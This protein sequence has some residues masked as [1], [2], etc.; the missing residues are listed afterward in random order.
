MPKTSRHSYHVMHG[1]D[2][3][4]CKAKGFLWMVS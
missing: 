1:G 3:T 2:M 4:T